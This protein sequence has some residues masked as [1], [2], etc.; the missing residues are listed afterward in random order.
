MN[1]KISFVTN[2]SVNTLDHIKL[3]LESL[4]SNLDN[5]EHEILVFV[6]SDNE[7]IADY[8]KSIKKSYYDLKV[9]T[10]KL[11][12][13][14]GYA[15]NNNLLVDL[16]KYDIVSY[17]QSDMVIGPHYDTNILSELEDNCILSST[18]VEPPLHGYSD[19][20]IT[21]NFGTDPTQFDM[22][23]WNHYSESVKSNRAAEYFFAPITFY[24]K[25][26]QS[27]GGYD[28]MFRR[29]REDSDLVQ[30][31]IH[32]GIK[33]I[34][35]WQANV[36]HFT[37]TSSRG[38]NWFDRKNTVAQERAKMQSLADQI[39]LRRFIRKWGNFNH[40][41]SK[42]IKL[43]IDLVIN[44]KTGLSVEQVFELAPYFSRVWFESHQDKDLA[45]LMHSTE[46]QPANELLGFSEEDWSRSKK[47]YNLIDH[48]SIYRVG[49]PENFNIKVTLKDS[50]V[51]SKN[52]IFFQ[53]INHM[54]NVIVTSD[55]GVYELGSA[56]IE[57]RNVVDLTK[58][59]IKVVNPPFDMNLLMIE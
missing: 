47:Y 24:K 33:L 58:D 18:R 14:I 41:E 30:R 54:A 57:I 51:S 4:K 53:Y 13:C 32:A 21:E 2:A 34:Q 48:E 9:I 12:P 55:P 35:T 16:A 46:H 1:K 3:L 23:R 27:I 59:S 25:V 39:E 17:L 6:D 26:W 29:S 31:C 11:K 5:K 22:D 36:Y 52:D 7:G 49:E 50:N 45:I 56:N 40:G 43:D 10:H 8:I 28:T 37:C 42:L 38:K 20:T 15:R 44:E 19:Y